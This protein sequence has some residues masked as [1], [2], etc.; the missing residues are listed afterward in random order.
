MVAKSIKRPQNKGPRSLAVESSSARQE[1]P[2]HYK[3]KSDNASPDTLDDLF[4]AA[5]AAYAQQPEASTSSNAF[6]DDEDLILLDGK[7][8]NGDRHAR[9]R[10]PQSGSGNQNSRR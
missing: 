1:S 6:A 10:S 8:Q 2:D 4:Q 9:A 7:D 3:E 5:I